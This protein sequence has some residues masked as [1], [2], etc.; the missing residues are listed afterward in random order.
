M[1]EIVIITGASGNLAKSVAKKLEID[2]FVVFFYSSNLSTINNKNIFYWDIE[3]G[4]FDKA[5]LANCS[6]IIHLSGYGV[7]NKWTKTN[8][9]KMYVSRVNAANLLFNYCKEKKINIKTFISASAI[10]YYGFDSVGIKEESDL[11]ATDWLAKLAVDWEKSA[12]A[13]EEIN[14]RVIKLRISLI[15]TK[16]SGFLKPILLSMKFG[17]APILGKRDQSFEWIHLDDLSNFILFSLKNKNVTGSYNLATESKTNQEEFLNIIKNKYFKYSLLIKIPTFMLRLLL[18][19]RRK[20]LST[21][22]AVSVKKL[23]STGFTFQ[24]PNVDIAI[25]KELK[26]KN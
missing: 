17:V 6:H 1:K 15:F 14:S 7:I 25:D 18:G 21:D 8:K 24:Y 12:T 26:D 13:F 5:P 3:N 11:P 9:K 2:G 20:I 19:Q 10:G 4:L 16:L 22:I 23:M